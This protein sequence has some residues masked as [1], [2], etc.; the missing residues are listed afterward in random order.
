MYQ[1]HGLL[2]QQPSKAKAIM[3]L[4]SIVLYSKS[5]PMGSF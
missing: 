4:K 3:F 1:R 2:D 5:S